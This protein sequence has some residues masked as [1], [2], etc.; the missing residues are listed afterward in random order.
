MPYSSKEGKF[1]ILDWIA[2][3]AHSINTVLDIG[4]GSGTY[5]HL[6]AEKRNLLAHSIWI[7]VEVWKN[8]I[9]EFKLTDRYNTILNCDV[10][11]L[12]WASLNTINLTIVGDILEHMTKEEAI[13]LIDHI[14]NNS[15]ICIISIPIVHYPQGEEFGNP[16]EAHIKDD[17]SHNEMMNTFDRYIKKFEIDGDIGVYWLE[18]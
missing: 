9:D 16:Y 4:V 6:L 13:V 12:D 7:G 1:A 18:I 14:M 2:P 5:K 8:Y 11:N 3:V 10:R 15:K 17:W